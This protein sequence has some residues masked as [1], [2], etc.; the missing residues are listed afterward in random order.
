MKWRVGEWECA[1]AQHTVNLF[2]FYQSAVLFL[3]F[4]FADSL[5]QQEVL[6]LVHAGACELWSCQGLLLTLY[7]AWHF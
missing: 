1:H 4:Q 3:D 6:R 2:L 5:Q 7:Q